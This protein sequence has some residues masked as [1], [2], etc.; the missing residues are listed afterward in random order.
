MGNVKGYYPKDAVYFT[1]Y[2]TLKGIMEKDNPEIYDYDVPEKLRRN[3]TELKTMAGI[4]IRVRFLFVLLQI[5]IQQEAIQVV[6]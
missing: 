1:Y 2:T 6:R 3:Y 4:K 5:T